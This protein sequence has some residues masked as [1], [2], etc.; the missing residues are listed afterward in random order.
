MTNT[1]ESEPAPAQSVASELSALHRALLWAAELH[2]GEDR[3]GENPLPY[4]THAVD[5]LMHLRRSGCTESDLLV[6]ACLHDVVEWAGGSLDGIHQQYGL[7]VRD[8]VAQ[9]TRTEPDPETLPSSS[10]ERH[11]IR[12]ELLLDDIRRMDR[13]AM[14]IKLADRR[15]NIAEKFLVC[16]PKKWRRYQQET[17]TI[18][19]MIPREVSPL[20]W[21]E[22]QEIALRDQPKN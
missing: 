4:L 11:A 10:E 21:D 1:P 13:E 6:A 15:S 7:R 5:V 14:W 19:Q 9:L 20:L 8:L 18:L 3:D 17:S 22:I 16:K 12:F 2:A